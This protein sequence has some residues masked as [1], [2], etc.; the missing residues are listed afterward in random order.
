MKIGYAGFEFPE[1]KLKFI[2]SRLK[3][4]EEKFDPRKVTPFFAEFIKDEFVKCDCVL[5]AKDSLLDLLILDIDKCEVRME[6]TEDP[7]ERQ[8]ISKCLEN[9]EDEIPLCNVDFSEEEAEML[10]TLAPL[11]IKPTAVLDEQ[12]DVNV[13][14]ATALKAAGVMFVYTA[15]KQEVHAWLV[16]VGSD[17]VT[18]AGRIHSDL[19]RGFIK[20]DVVKIDELLAAHNFN[21]ARSKG[22]V[23]IVDR[24]Y[25]IEDG[26][27]I[28][29]RFNV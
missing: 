13:A 22:V 12:P 11:S 16:P 28:E 19:A 17:A 26:D 3:K 18:C 2:D 27:V 4:L 5:I 10:K 25:V 24:D 20:A 23:K 7:V 14:I 9:L 29:I 21:D 15:G 1:G 8:L 6:R